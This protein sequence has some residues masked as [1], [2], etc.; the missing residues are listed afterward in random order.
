M[1]LYTFADKVV[2]VS[3]GAELKKIEKGEIMFS[4][5]CH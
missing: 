3:D 2:L 4:I 1:K 5:K